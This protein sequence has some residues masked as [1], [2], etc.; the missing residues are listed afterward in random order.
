MTRFLPWKI[1]GYQ[2]YL[3][4]LEEYEDERFLK[5]LFSKGLFPIK[6]LRKNLVLTNKVKL[7]L[8]I[9]LVIKLAI[10]I[11]LAYLASPFFNISST[12]T[13]ILLC[14]AFFYVT[15]I[16]HFAF[17]IQA[18]WITS[19]F[20]GIAKKRMIKQ[21][22][23][24]L[25]KFKNI[26]IIGITGSY[27]K[28]SMKEVLKTVLSERF[29]VVATKGNNNTPLGVA[30]TIINNVTDNTEILIIEVGEYKKG[31][32][33]EICTIAPPH[34]SIITGINE[35]HLERYGSMENAIST[36]FEITEITQPNP[37]IYLNA[38]DELTK[39]NYKRLIAK[40]L[41]VN[42][43]SARN[44]DLSEIKAKDIFFDT[45]KPGISFSLKHNATEIENINTN[46]IS[47]YIIGYSA[48]CTLIALQLGMTA[49]E[50][51]FALG[52]IKPFEHRLE[53]KI[54]PNNILII[55]DTYNGNSNG[56]KEGISILKKFKDRRKVY[57][58][59]GLVETGAVAEP[60][61]NEIGKWL[62]SVV[63]LVIL[64]KNSVTPFI[65]DGLVKA[66]FDKSK[67]VWYYSS[68]ETY[69]K[70]REHLQPNDV[71]LMQNDWS[72]NYV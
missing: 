8:A 23:N 45:K 56:I 57:V 5:S 26:K 4:Q 18:A 28:T 17:A 13:Y 51:K 69:E 47:E 61:H 65:F 25:G 32:V 34:I 71:V 10:S 15:D 44:D 43:F 68:K 33:A 38:D 2:L 24:K 37:A 62:A 66:G 11:A 22:K 31:D 42:F 1:I 58:T 72:D 12:F 19:P 20:E 50:I 40:D 7:N 46:F 14:I 55:D 16:F 6:D 3:F 54:N 36:K 63:D 53:A 60:I 67:I 49:S 35:A 70:L 9:A 48:A 52:Q 27:G 41:E 59:P 21:A 29:K 64:T 30:R 39:Q